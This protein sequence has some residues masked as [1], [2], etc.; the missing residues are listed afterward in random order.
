M[1][2]ALAALNSSL[3]RVRELAT[4]ISRETSLALSD[5][6]VLARHETQQCGAV[7]LLTGY[8]ETFLKDVVKAYLASLCTTGIPFASL[9]EK[10]RRTHFEAG[11]KVITE[12]ARSSGR[13]PRFGSISL[14]DAVFRLYS[15]TA[16]EPT[17][18][19]LWEAFAD[20]GQN[21]R[22]NVVKEILNN[23][24][25]SEV[26]PKLSN[27]VSLSLQRTVPD[28]ALIINL[29]N[30]IEIRNECAHTGRV[31]PI[32]GPSAIIEFASNLGQIGSGIV[33][34][35]TDEIQSHEAFV[36]QLSTGRVA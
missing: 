35:L 19:I 23:L 2:T 34:L 1:Q 31:S 26:W 20:T 7:V 9:P 36:S 3:D 27:R 6:T 4:F 15:P 11:G 5:P 14:E 28:S 10:L 18:S 32:P 8:F 17:Y 12:V 21:P 22:P 13:V 30:L 16:G 33:S 24:G 29:E 25:I